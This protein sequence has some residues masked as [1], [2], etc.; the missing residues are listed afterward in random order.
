MNKK[1]IVHLNI[2]V[3]TFKYIIVFY[4]ILNP[5]DSAQFLFDFSAGCY[6]LESIIKLTYNVNYL[7]IYIIYN[8]LNDNWSFFGLNTLEKVC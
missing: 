7:I 1:L 4:L 8:L 2:L 5:E 3:C 6:T